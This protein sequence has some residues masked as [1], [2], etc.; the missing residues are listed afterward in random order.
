MISFA[1]KAAFEMMSADKRHQ[2][3]QK[4]VSALIKNATAADELDMVCFVAVDLINRIPKEK[5]T[6][7]TERVLYARMNETAGNKALSVPD[8]CSAVKYAES[9]LAFLGETSY[10][11]THHDLMLN[12]HKTSA[13]ALYS[14]SNGNQ[15]L[16]KERIHSVF[17][18]AANIKEEFKTRLVWIK[19]VSTISLQEA[20][21][22]CHILLERLGEP[23]TSSDISPAY[24]ASEL[25]RIK[26]SLLDGR[27][28]LSAQMTECNKVKAMR[29]MSYLVDFYHMQRRHTAVIISTRMVE[30][31]LTHGCTEESYFALASFGA[32]LV[33]ILKDID[34]GCVVAR[35][36][37]ALMSKSRY[38]INA[39]LPPVYTAIYGFALIWVEPL[40]VSTCLFINQ[41]CL[42]ITIVSHIV[43]FPLQMIQSVMEP[44]LQAVQ[45]AFGYGNIV[46]ATNN[47]KVNEDCAVFL[48]CFTH[49]HLCRYLTHFPHHMFSYT[50]HA[51]FI[52]ERIVSIE[53]LFPLLPVEYHLTLSMIP[54]WFKSKLI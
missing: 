51:C 27:N 6:D 11:E 49:T 21:N 3:S 10:W 43:S 28:Q 9:G 1:L 53:M 46:K 35:M 37:L 12:L 30:I 5:V 40:Q 48:S 45:L 39:M 16:L 36:S 14:C 19:F 29:V 22:E 38:N 15:D 32:H 31:S 8:F 41:I 26:N 4:L 34:N 24:A 42:D 2:L 20:I 17:Q 44:L 18:H 23:I 52:A 47:A 25:V 7:C 54:T 33:A 13:A 50:S